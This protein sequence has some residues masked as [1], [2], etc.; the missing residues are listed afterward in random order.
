MAYS[1]EITIIG[2]GAM[3]QSLANA[4]QKKG[5]RI[6][7]VVSRSDCKSL[8]KKR[9]YALG[10]SLNEIEIGDVIFLCLPDDQLEN[11]AHEIAETIS[12]KGKTVYH[13]SG[14]HNAD[15]LSVLKLQGAE[16]GSTHPLQTFVRN[17]P[18]SFEGI[19]VS[20]NGT[21]AANVLAKQIFER[22]GAH[23]FVI[24]NQQKVK[25][26][27]AAVMVCNY[28]V[29]LVKAAEEVLDFPDSTLKQLMLPLMH[30]TLKNISEKSLNEALTGPV[31]RG[32][33]GTIQK[34]LAAMNEG[35]HKDLY[36]MLGNFA[37][38]LTNHHEIQ[39]FFSNLLKK[40]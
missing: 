15:V 21:P 8:D 33:L 18:A 24:D 38:S 37:A 35:N 25:L 7:S 40:D 13:T 29:A 1:P 36:L 22:L 39:S 16:I 17:E 14:V 31:A 5:F 6:I 12:W 34:H 2:L 10:K 32:D 4:L 30:Q 28:Y 11:Y 9:Y 20:L 3:G 26:H 23:T 19:W 27:T